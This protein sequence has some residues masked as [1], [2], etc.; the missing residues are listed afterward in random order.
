MVETDWRVRG[1][2]GATTAQENS[3][4]AINE[5]VLELVQNLISINQLFPE[6][7]VMVQFTCT[8]DLDACFP[9]QI[10]RESLGWEQ[11]AFLDLAHL[12]VPN[13]L[14]LC[15][16]VIIQINT[17]KTQDQMQPVYLR[18]ARNLRPDLIAANRSALC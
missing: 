6:N 9:S 15:I 7:I 2:R 18:G 16:R 5:A 14:K 3:R 13:S 4:Q 1:V 12:P 8:P 11:V 10:V 17:P